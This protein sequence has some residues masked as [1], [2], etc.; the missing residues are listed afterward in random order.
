V[1]AVAGLSSLALAQPVY[2]VLRR[3]PEFFAIRDLYLADLL[4]LLAV[5]AVAPT[6][7][8]SAPAA[9]FRLSRPSWLRP[10]IAAPIGLLSAVI[11]LQAV[12][13][14]PAAAAITAALFVG[15]GVVWA[16]LRLRSVRTFALLLSVAAII[17]PAVLALDREVRRSM[18]DP[19]RTASANLTDT[20]A[21]APIVLVVFDEWSLTSILDSEG[22]IDRKRLPNL[23][24]LADQ[25]TWYPNAT[26]ASD[27]SELAL[28]AMLT[29]SRA[30]PEL[31]PTLS[32]HPVN[33]F[34]LLAPSHD[35][36]ALEPVAR[37]CPP[38]SNL[39][40][41]RRP[42]FRQRFALLISDLSIVWLSRTL[43]GGW[44]ARLPTVERTWSG[45]GRDHPAARREP[46]ASEPARRALFNVMNSDRAADF[47][48]LVASIGSSSD[49]P[50]LHFAHSLL[51]HTPWEY[52]PSGRTYHSNRGR[53]EGL[54][55]QGW[56]ADPWPVL[57]ARKRYLL[58][59]EFVD[60]LIGELTSRLKSVG[61]FDASLIAIAADHG[62]SFRPGESHRS[63]V[64]PSSSPD[65]L[66][67][68]ATVPL[69]IK[70]PF[71]NKAHVEE[72]PTSLV[73]LAPR[74]LELAGAEPDKG[75][76]PHPP[77][78]VT[79]YVGNLEIPGDR[80]SW[81][82][83][84]ALE[85][86]NL[87]GGSS[88]VGTIGV[89][90]D[91][92]GLNTA[93]MTIT[94]PGDIEIRLEGADLWDNV[95]LDHA[96]LPARVAGVLTGPESLPDRTAAITVNGVVAATVR[97]W[98]D[99]DGATRL[100]ALLP[101]RL[102]RPGFNQIE[103]FLTAN[104]ASR[105]LEWVR[106]PA[107]FVYELTRSEQ[108]PGS[109]LLKRPRS[110]L[111]ADV[112]SIPIL[113]RDDAQIVGFLEDGHRADAPLSGWAT[114]LSESGST[115]LEIVAF[116][117]GRQ[118][119][120]GVTNVERQ[121]VA[122][123]YGQGHLHSGF[124]R[125]AQPRSRGDAKADAATL[126][127]IRREGL[128]AYAVSVSGTASRLRF[129]YAPLEGENDEEVLPVSD[130]RRLPVRHT[131]GRFEG[132]VDV[133]SKPGKRT[134]IEGWAADLERGE[135]PRQIVVYRDGEFLVA[136]GANRQRA[137]VA[138]HHR[139]PR[140]LRT[141]FRAAVPDA[142]EPAAFTGRH[143]VFA[144]ML[145]GTAVELPVLEAAIASSH[146]PAS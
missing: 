121:S 94:L 67:D 146:E 144:L 107:G 21:R 137:D 40:A 52:L 66:L 83:K 89:R 98:R 47:R 4:V 19:G 8:L 85:Q 38:G 86:A 82:L 30:A 41:E 97:P 142:P 123:R 13:R 104:D 143:R 74:L 79:K 127:A 12:A 90:P 25:A 59:V 55:R 76:R 119:W 81:R 136:L 116:L 106:R 70:A 39:L 115:G 139:D 72:T 37:L 78:M 15:G 68:V 1:L 120:A 100:A 26:A 91:L 135:R 44:R 5:V 29:G 65:Q 103:V 122:N 69:V 75:R 71:Q 93:G 46:R 11:A 118:Y 145:A 60:R 10:A 9:L 36:Y 48:R 84:E 128:V 99:I 124:S 56:T 129:Y 140:L 43:P 7:L 23:A 54:E 87:L 50:S 125:K 3:A 102:L 92:H 88:D 131:G 111:D 73:D 141:G 49:R 34:T 62:I 14:L 28:P 112:V 24:R 117:G 64:P 133:V 114:D 110:G 33:L 80:R 77:V 6:L 61:L 113:R 105:R 96:E 16:Y 108:G 101:E 126:K 32:E 132:A 134:L 27:A 31:L 138:E 130:G 45:F 57:H 95:D 51:P 2:D 109:A 17:V 63:P 20:G 22:Q 42:G 53:I 58:Q 35:I 18:P